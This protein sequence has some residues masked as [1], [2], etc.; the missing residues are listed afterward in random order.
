MRAVGDKLWVMGAVG[1]ERW[2]M[3][4]VHVRENILVIK[5]NI[6]ILPYFLNLFLKR[7]TWQGLYRYI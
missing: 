2:V 4:D 1:D 3:G 6:L 7:V 5:L